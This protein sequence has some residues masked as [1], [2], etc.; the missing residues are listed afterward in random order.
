MDGSRTVEIS[1]WDVPLA[2][3]QFESWV[4]IYA[5]P[6]N[7][8]NTRRHN[9]KVWGNYDQ[10]RSPILIQALKYLHRIQWILFFFTF[11]LSADQW[12][13]TAACIF[14]TWS[15]N[16]QPKNSLVTFQFHFKC[17]LIFLKSK[18]GDKFISLMKTCVW[19]MSL[20]SAALGVLHFWT[21]SSLSSCPA[22]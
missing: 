20:L 6:W 16:I 19:F 11:D 17:M 13:L 12:Y 8:F 3:Q 5:A 10:W 9:C 22:G 21:W 14:S 18:R 7:Q 2:E 15:I 4:W 1:S